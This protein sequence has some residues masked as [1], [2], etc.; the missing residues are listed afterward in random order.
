MFFDEKQSTVHLTNGRISYVMQVLDGKYLL[1]RY[2]GLALRG[3]HGTGVPQPTKRSYTTEYGNSCLYFDALPWE[4][5]TRGRGDYRIPAMSVTGTAGAPVSELLFRSWRVLDKKTGSD[6]L[7]VTFSADDESETFVLLNGA[8]CRTSKGELLCA[9]PLPLRDARH[10]VDILY[11]HQLGFEMNTDRGD[12]S[13]DTVLCDTA[14]PMPQLTIFW[15]DAPQV[16]K[17]FAFSQDTV[18]LERARKDLSCLPNVTVTVSAPWNLEITAYEA[19]KGNMALWAV[20]QYGLKPDEALVFGDGYNDENLF[21]S[22]T[23]TRA[24]GNAVAFLKEI[25]E[26]VIEPNTQNGVAREIE[27][28]LSD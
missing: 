11:Q 28:L 25:A 21:Q 13:T 16:R 7:P 3:W 4:Y 5:P 24:M 20:E 9:R 2:F 27:R 18:T 23:H 14:V 6:T 1:H 22:F 12:F 15:S 17:I 8:E 26:K 19:K 10:A